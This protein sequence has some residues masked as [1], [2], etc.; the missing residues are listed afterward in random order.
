MG[1]VGG[2]GMGWVWQSLVVKHGKL[3]VQCG[4][5]RESESEG[6][7]AMGADDFIW[8]QVFVS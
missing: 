4:T 2:V 7:V 8:A 1:L 5:E 6:V 3:G